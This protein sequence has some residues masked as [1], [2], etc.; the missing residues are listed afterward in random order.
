MALAVALEVSNVDGR[1]GVA[2]DAKRLFDGRS[3]SLGFAADVREVNAAGL[4]DDLRD[5]G[6]LVGIGVEAGRVD[7]AAGHAKRAVFHRVRKKPLHVVEFHRFGRPLR[8]PDGN[9]AQRTLADD[10]DDIGGGA[11]VAKGFQV[12]GQ[13]FPGPVHVLRHTRMHGA[14]ESALLVRRRRRGEATHADDLRSDALADRTLSFRIDEQAEVGMGVHVY[15]A[16]G[17]DEPG[18]IESRA[19]T[20]RGSRRPQGCRA[21]KARR[22]PAASAPQCHP[23]PTR[24]ARHNHRLFQPSA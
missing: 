18:G 20:R 3:E 13:G 12:F 15:E 17:D 22:P 19:P 16:G 14:H 6:Q 5:R 11:A 23:L 2:T 1:A 9:R 10:R 8:H 7:Q 24:P 21:A 4:R